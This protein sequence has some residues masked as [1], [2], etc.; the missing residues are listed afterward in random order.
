MSKRSAQEKIDRYRAKIRKLE[1]QKPRKRNRVIYSDSPDEE[2]NEDIIQEREPPIEEPRRNIVVHE[3]QVHAEPQRRAPIAEPQRHAPIGE[4]QRRAPIGEPQRHAPIGEPQR[5]A[6]IGEIQRDI[7][8]EEPQ[9]DAP[10]DDQ[11]LPC[12]AAQEPQEAEAPTI[13]PDLDP[14]I[15]SALGESTDDSPKYGPVIHEKLA[16]LWLPLLRKG[17]EKEAKEKLIKL[18]LIPENCALLQAPKLNPEIS[19]AVSDATRARDKRVESVQQQLGAGITALNRGLEL[20]LE[21]GSD[22]LQAVKFLSESSRILCDLHFVETTARKKFI[23]T[24]LDKAFVNVIQDVD[25]DDTLFGNKLSEKIK[26]SKMIE[27]QGLQIKKVTPAKATTAPS[28]QPS[29]SRN[30]PQGNWSAAPRFPPSNRGGRGAPRKTA[31]AGRGAP[32]TG[33]SKSSEQTKRRAPYRR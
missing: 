15:L 32:L 14:E 25:R 12:D 26:A 4:P 3:A 27:K 19:A 20:L 21:E 18:H 22:R 33:Q 29:T 17:M 31:P 23:T 10:P 1:Q 8:V 16:R 5:R 24:A 30:R 6:P 28:A 2:P 13:E 7:A 9:R 11:P